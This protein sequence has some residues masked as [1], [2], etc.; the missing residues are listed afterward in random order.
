MNSKELFQAGSLAEAIAAAV[1]E[2][3]QHP[4]DISHR[5]FLCELLCFAGDLERADRQLS[6]IG[7]QEPHVTAGVGLFRQLL[8]AE[9]ARRDFH[10][11]GR[12]PEFLAAPSPQLQLHLQ[13]A[14]AVREGKPQEALE[15]LEQAEEQRPMVSGLCNGEPFEDFRDLDDLCASLL[16]VLTSNGKYYWVPIEQVERLEFLPPEHPRDLAWRRTRLEI[17]GG[18]DGEVYLP[19]L[20]VGSEASPDDRIRLGRVTEWTGGEQSPVRGIGQRMFLVGDDSRS[21]L[22]LEEL[23]ISNVAAPVSHGE[24]RT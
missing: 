21:I 24:N 23:T 5:V 8:A 3:R 6:T 10:A 13:A 12:V 20:Y 9:Q 2:V 15:L 18:P 22:E 4:A 11:S 17:R 19:A 1:E 14:I 16:E 7:F